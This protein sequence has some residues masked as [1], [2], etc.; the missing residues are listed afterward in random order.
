VEFTVDDKLQALGFAARYHGHDGWREQ[1][2]VFAS[3]W[4]ELN[5]TPEQLVDLGDRVVVRIK[6]TARGTSSG[7]AVA[8]TEGHVMHFADGAVVRQDQ[9]W[10]WAELVDALG[11]DD[12]AP[13]GV[14]ALA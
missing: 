3:Q 11:L 8:K 6:V 1:V 9:H 13:A 14:S 2:R 4:A 12:H 5:W 7:A 10:D